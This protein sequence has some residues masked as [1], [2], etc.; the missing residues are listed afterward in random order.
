MASSAATE[1]LHRLAPLGAT[2]GTPRLRARE[3]HL[4]QGYNK[5]QDLQ[6]NVIIFC[7][8]HACS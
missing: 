4:V 5:F 7:C 2:H 3:V 1:G 8:G 6:A